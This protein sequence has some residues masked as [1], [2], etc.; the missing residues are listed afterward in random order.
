MDLLD[1]KGED[2]YFER[3]LPVEVESLL[4]K[5][6]K[7]YPAPRTEA[8]LTRAYFLEPQHLTVLVAL[9]RFYYYRHRYADA[10]LVADRSLQAAGRQLGVSDDW[11][12]FDP[13]RL[14]HGA[15]V[16]LG[17]TRFYL[18]ALKGAGYLQL[19][20]GDLPGALERLEKLAEL[21]PKDQL[22][23]EPLIELARGAVGA[24]RA[25]N[26]A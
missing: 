3:A 23:A 13:A 4:R 22:G 17:L 11:R 18:L 20:L 9:Y 26:D 25:A 8:L 19:R 12:R 5:A 16:S 24:A 6:A 2:L 7:A 14:G 21:D 15:M 10:L 1:F